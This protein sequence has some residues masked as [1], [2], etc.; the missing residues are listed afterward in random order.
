MFR[1]EWKSARASTLHVFV[2]GRPWMSSFWWINWLALLENL[3]V[4]RFMLKVKGITKVCQA[5][6]SANAFTLHVFFVRPTV[7]EPFWMN[8]LACTFFVS[9]V[10]FENDVKM[11]EFSYFVKTCYKC[12]FFGCP[13]L[14]LCVRALLQQFKFQIEFTLDA[15]TNS[16]KGCGLW[17]YQQ[18][19]IAL[20]FNSQPERNLD[21][22][23]KQQHSQG[24]QKQQKRNNKIQKW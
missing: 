8:K 14:F 5:W 2:S 19:F 7:N 11:L 17:L 24:Q 20:L 21:K 3:H 6:K 9:E 23:A 4:N 16:H 1:Q 22:K 10:S 18:K 13:C 12:N 15:Q